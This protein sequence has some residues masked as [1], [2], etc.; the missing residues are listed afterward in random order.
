MKMLGLILTL[1]ISA[2]TNAATFKSFKHC[3]TAQKVKGSELILELQKSGSK[4]QLVIKPSGQQSET[5]AVK[6]LV[7]HKI[8]GSTYYVGKDIGTDNDITLAITNG[9]AP[10]KAGNTVGRPSYFT[11]TN[12]FKDLLMVCGEV[13]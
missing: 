13:R 9:T 12:I 5:I 11:I 3:E 6:E 4:Y 8:G 7:T 2:S 1:I 10:I